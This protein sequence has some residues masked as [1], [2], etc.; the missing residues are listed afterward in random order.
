MPLLIR[1]A[2]L[3]RSKRAN[4]EEGKK[5]LKLEN[6]KAVKVASQEKPINWLPKAHIKGLSGQNRA[7]CV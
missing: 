3:S 4:T 6:D 2:F 1:Q 7:Q 5:K